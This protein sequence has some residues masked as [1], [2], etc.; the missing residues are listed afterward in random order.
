MKKFNDLEFKQHKSIKT[1]VCAYV[2]FPNSEWISV[3]GCPE[4]TFYGN[5]TTSFEIMSSSTEKTQRGVK[6]WLSKAQITRHMIY[7]QKK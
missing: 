3:I 2:N 4:G 6:G 5:G 7:L 1:A